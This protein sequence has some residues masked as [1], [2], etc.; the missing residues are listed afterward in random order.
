MRARAEALRLCAS[1]QVGNPARNSRFRPPARSA[2]AGGRH[3]LALAA[4][5]CAVKRRTLNLFLQRH[6]VCLASRRYN[7]C[8]TLK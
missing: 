1:V 7:L 4:G 2:L 8:A 6:I 3:V 5:A